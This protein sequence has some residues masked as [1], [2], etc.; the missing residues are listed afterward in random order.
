LILQFV[1]LKAGLVQEFISGAH[2]AFQ[3]VNRISNTKSCAF[4][5]PAMEIA[6]VTPSLDA[7]DQTDFPRFLE[8]DDST[9]FDESDSHQRR[10][11]RSIYRYE[12]VLFHNSPDAVPTVSQARSRNG[13]E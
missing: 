12:R 9:S 8:S 13:A 5:C 11:C 7:A 10:N 4:M 2:C 3:T 1:A 6:S